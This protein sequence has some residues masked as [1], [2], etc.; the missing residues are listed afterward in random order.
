MLKSV[1]YFF[2]TV[3]RRPWS[4]EPRI[5][6]VF[7]FFLIKIPHCPLR[8]LKSFQNHFILL[9]C[10]IYNKSPLHS[11][12]KFLINFSDFFRALFGLILSDW[13]INIKFMLN[14]FGVH[15]MKNI[16]FHVNLSIC[17]NK[18]I[19]MNMREQF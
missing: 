18:W 10:N 5:T 9:D 17:E 14:G 4:R 2:S 19:A 12:S 3:F 6:L 7:F 8:F 16:L 1:R 15:L 13:E 11:D